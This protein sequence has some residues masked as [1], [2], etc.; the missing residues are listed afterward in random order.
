MNTKAIQKPFKPNF[1]SFIMKSGKKISGGRYKNP[2][3]KGKDSRNRQERITKI[4]EMKT[5]LIRTKGGNSKLTA[6]LL[7]KANVIVNKKAKKTKELFKGK[8]KKP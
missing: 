4:G 5:K 3:K 1:L 2:K 6:T 8:K 7:D